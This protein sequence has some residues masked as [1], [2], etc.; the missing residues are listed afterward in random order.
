MV[1]LILIVI[2]LLAL[3]LV[4]RKNKGCKHKSAVRRVEVDSRTS[5]GFAV[6]AERSLVELEASCRPAV[7][8]DDMPD[9]VSN[10]WKSE[11][12]HPELDHMGRYMDTSGSDLVTPAWN[13]HSIQ[14]LCGSGVEAMAKARSPSKDLEFSS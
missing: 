9:L 3:L 5:G 7:H 10:M 1:Y 11:T 2:L 4:M 14:N 12:S 8:D 13:R 6:G